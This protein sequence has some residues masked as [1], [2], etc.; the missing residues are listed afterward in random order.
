MRTTPRL[1]FA[2]IAIPGEGRE[3]RSGRAPDD[4]L[5]RPAWRVRQLADGPDATLGQPCLGRW[6]YSPHQLDGEIVEEGKLALRVDN[7]EA[8]GL[9]H[10]R[11]NLREMLGAC[12]PDR[13]RKANIGPH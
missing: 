5:Q 4:P 2:R 6:T 8:V 7:H 13:D 12:H 3:L 1:D 9:G 11:G 10:L